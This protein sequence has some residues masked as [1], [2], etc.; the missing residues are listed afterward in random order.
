MAAFAMGQTDRD[1]SSEIPNEH[2]AEV[3]NTK[4]NIT[5]G[6]DINIYLQLYMYY[7]DVSRWVKH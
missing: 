4:Y 5:F 7:A 2:N 3:P 6:T 1:T